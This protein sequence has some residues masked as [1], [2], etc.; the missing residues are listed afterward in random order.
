MDGSLKISAHGLNRLRGSEKIAY[1]KEEAVPHACILSYQPFI[2]WSIVFRKQW[3]AP[4]SHYPL[5]L[6][7]LTHCPQSLEC[8]DIKSDK[9][10][11]SD[12]A[13]LSLMIAPQNDELLTEE[14]L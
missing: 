11:L 9:V 14:R 10:H 6:D 8:L 2:L 7:T 12:Q 4:P 13:L 5:I 1:P 3:P